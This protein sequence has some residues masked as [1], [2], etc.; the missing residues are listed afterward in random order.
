VIFVP[1]GKWPVPKSRAFPYFRYALFTDIH[2]HSPAGNR[3]RM[4]LI[5]SSETKELKCIYCGSYEALPFEGMARIRIIP[6]APR[7]P[8]RARSFIV[9]RCLYCGR[10]FDEGK[11][12]GME[13]PGEGP[14]LLRQR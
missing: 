7:E 12:E 1:S 9:Y 11:L 3:D 5:V 10:T 2:S 4:G 6:G 8:G 13:R 14:G